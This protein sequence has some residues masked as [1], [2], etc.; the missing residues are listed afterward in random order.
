[1][2]VANIISKFNLP[3]QEEIDPKHLLVVIDDQQDIRLILL[4]HLNK[5]GFK[6]IRMFKDGYQALKFLETCK[7]K[8]SIIICDFFMPAISGVDF[9]TELKEGRD[10]KRPPVLM[11]MD[12][13]NKDKVM[14]ALE[15]DID[16]VLVKPFVLDDIAPK[17]LHAFS[18]FHNSKPIEHLHLLAKSLILDNMPYDARGVYQAIATLA[19]N[20]ARPWLGM[21]RVYMSE[22]DLNGAFKCVK[23]A[24]KRNPHHAHIYSIRGEIFVKAGYLEKACSSFRRAIKTSPLNPVRYEA[25]LD[26][27]ADQGLFDEIIEVG[28][29][30]VLHTIEFPRLTHHLSQAYINLKD[31][32][33]A[34]RYLKLALT[35][36][37][38][39]IQYLNQLGICYKS[40]KRFQEA[41]KIYNRV[42]KLD[43][44]NINALFNKAVLLKS[45]GE[46]D[47]SI[48]LLERIVRRHPD[49]EKAHKKLTT[50]R[51]LCY[52]KAV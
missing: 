8:I 39:N 22:G 6:N 49:F 2:S 24:K 19:E 50:Y 3:K 52:D 1:M 36:E 7:E 17:L 9:L 23:E 14:Y 32:K 35:D 40:E 13:A 10:L 4:H 18:K 46:L 47:R 15:H 44:D 25:T 29:T 28:K 45:M 5:L 12:N 31:F 43:P 21:A 27:L 16:E 34:I 30:A 41:N 26:L 38:N 33:N 48:R 20:C 37:P 51:L 11:T 42:I